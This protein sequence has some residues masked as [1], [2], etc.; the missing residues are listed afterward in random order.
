VTTKLRESFIGR[1]LAHNLVENQSIDFGC[2]L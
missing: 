1:E 2:V